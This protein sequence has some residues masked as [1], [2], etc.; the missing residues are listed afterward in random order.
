MDRLASGDDALLG[1]EIAMCY[2]TQIMTGRTAVSIIPPDQLSLPKSSVGPYAPLNV[3]SL[4]DSYREALPA[5]AETFVLRRSS[6]VFQLIFEKNDSCRPPVLKV[7][8]LAGTHV[9]THPSRELE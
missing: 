8:N 4:T 2:P 6:T 3:A 9:P 5:S 1:A 7:C